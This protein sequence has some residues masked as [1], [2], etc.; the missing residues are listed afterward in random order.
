MQRVNQLKEKSVE[1]GSECYLFYSLHD[2]IMDYL[3]NNITQ[4]EQKSYHVQLVQKYSDMCGGVFSEL[5]KDDYIHQQLLAHVHV[6]DN[7]EQLGQL[8]T[9]LLW[10]AACCKHWSASS[11]LDFY[12][13]HK[14]SVPKKVSCDFCSC[15]HSLKFAWDHVTLQFVILFVI[16]R[17]IS[18]IYFKVAVER[19]FEVIDARYKTKS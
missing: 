12:I 16:W 8:L 4:E 9:N 7:M 3:K 6:A 15:I 1:E 19:K 10:M 11:L 18:S 17:T 14:S 13:R 5:E 2:V